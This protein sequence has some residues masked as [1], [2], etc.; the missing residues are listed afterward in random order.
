MDR[1]FYRFA[2]MYRG[3]SK[4]DK[5]ADFAERMFKDTSFPREEKEFDPLSRYIEEL[6]DPQMP[7]AIFDD[8]FA[9]YKDRHG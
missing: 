7:S 5:N 6:A 3:G 9:V 2:L 8:L 4:D 1:S